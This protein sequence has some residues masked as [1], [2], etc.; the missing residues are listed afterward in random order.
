MSLKQIR[1]TNND[2]VMNKNLLPILWIPLQKLFHK[3]KNAQVKK[4]IRHAATIG[5]IAIKQ[6]KMDLCLEHAWFIQIIL[7][8]H[9]GTRVS[10]G[11]ENIVNSDMVK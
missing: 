9:E 5:G 1:K 10:G 11:N 7:P 3:H 8:L 6:L 2:T 4:T